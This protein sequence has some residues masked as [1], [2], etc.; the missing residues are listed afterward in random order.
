MLDT[1]YLI[2]Y[3]PIGHTSFHDVGTLTCRRGEQQEWTHEQ[4]WDLI[5]NNGQSVDPW[6]VRDSP[7]YKEQNPN[8]TWDWADQGIT[9]VEDWDEWLEGAR[10]LSTYLQCT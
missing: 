1:L 6:I 5:T 8:E 2:R 7:I 9:V 10:S 3:D 4:M